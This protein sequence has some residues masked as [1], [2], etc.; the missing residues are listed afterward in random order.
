MYDCDHDYEYC[1]LSMKDTGNHDIFD[2]NRASTIGD[3]FG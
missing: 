1:T 2:I 3:R